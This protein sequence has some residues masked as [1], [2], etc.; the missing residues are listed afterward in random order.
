MNR[1]K[2]DWPVNLIQSH[3]CYMSVVLA[4]TCAEKL[5]ITLLCIGVS[6][7][8]YFFG[9]G[10]HVLW[11]KPG[12]YNQLSWIHWIIIKNNSNSTTGNTTPD[13]QVCFNLNASWLA[14]WLAGIWCCQLCFMHDTIT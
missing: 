14:G 11:S 5:S 13:I 1:S 8:F 2:T 12:R 10:G 4:F 7:I 9:I 3:N 6:S